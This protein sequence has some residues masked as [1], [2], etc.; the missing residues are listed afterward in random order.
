MISKGLREAE[1]P[2]EILSIEIHVKPCKTLTPCIYDVRMSL[3]GN[4]Q[5]IGDGQ[6][7]LRDLKV[8]NSNLLT[9]F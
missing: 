2:Y 5:K 4:Y 3:G 8:Q 1:L 7:A 9:K 6:R